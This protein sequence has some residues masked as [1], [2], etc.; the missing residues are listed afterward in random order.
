M[1]NTPAATEDSPAWSPD[2]KRVVYSAQRAVDD[3]RRRRSQTALTSTPTV[4]EEEPA[5]SPDGTKIAFH[6][7]AGATPRSSPS[8]LPTARPAQLTDNTFADR[9]PAWAPDG[10]KLAF[11]SD[12]SGSSLIYLMTAGGANQTLFSLNPEV[13]T[14]PVWTHYRDSIAYTQQA[15]GFT[16]IAFD[17]VTEADTSGGAD[18]LTDGGGGT[19]NDTRTSFSLLA[20]PEQ[21][22]G[23]AAFQRQVLL[24][25]DSEIFKG[26]DTPLPETNL[27]NNAAPRHL[28]RLVAPAM[29]G[30]SP[31]KARLQRRP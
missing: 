15:T 28:P 4:I 21:G 11:D 17:S 8:T 5:W 9:S 29:I 14:D 31:E 13:Q 7:L 1:T 30:V 27:T 19:A 16:A 25:P 2:G 6:A 18:S 20:N 22:F 26:T 24:S 10:G 3:E 12:R 23:F